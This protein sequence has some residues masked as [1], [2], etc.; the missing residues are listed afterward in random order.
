V[1]EI[2]K[3]VQMLRVVRTEVEVARKMLAVGALGKRLF[4]VY[5]PQ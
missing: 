2:L 1:A 5:R 4:K 3:V